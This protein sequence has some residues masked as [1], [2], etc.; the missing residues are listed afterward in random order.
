MYFPKLDKASLTD[1]IVI[2]QV[3]KV[4][5]RFPDVDIP[6]PVEHLKEQLMTLGSATI[7]GLNGK[8][9]GITAGSRG[10]PYYK[11]LLKAMCDQLKEWGAKPFIFPAMGSH[12]GA[13]AEGQKTHDRQ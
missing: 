4:R 2:P 13:T 1:G 3:V 10:L 6:D 11:E 8:T 12:A 9:I 7:A 5:Q